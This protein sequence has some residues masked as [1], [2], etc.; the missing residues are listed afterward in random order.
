MFKGLSFV[1][2]SVAAFVT[3]R[4]TEWCLQC[5]GVSNGCIVDE[6]P[7]ILLDSDLLVPC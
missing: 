4:W 5:S 2:L 6:A 3:A 1:T 7:V